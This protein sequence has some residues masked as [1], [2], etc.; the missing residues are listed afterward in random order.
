MRVVSPIVY[1][2]VMY[3]AN[4]RG[5]NAASINFCQYNINWREDGR[6]SS[7]SW[8]VLVINICKAICNVTHGKVNAFDYI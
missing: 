3:S 8:M 1:I 5:F 6:A 7:G 4:I 2:C